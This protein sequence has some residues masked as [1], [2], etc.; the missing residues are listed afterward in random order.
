MTDLQILQQ[1]LNGNHL[2]PKEVLRAKEI[3]KRLNTE[4]QKR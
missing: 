3:L 1:L 4:L 2:E